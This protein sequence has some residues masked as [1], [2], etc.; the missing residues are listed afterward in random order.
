MVDMNYRDAS[1]KGSF[2]YKVLDI[3]T[4]N[5]INVDVS[6]LKSW[7]PAG[8]YTYNALANP[9][10]TSVF[11]FTGLNADWSKELSLSVSIDF[12]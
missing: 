10:G 2:F 12:S 4:R 11:F 5:D 9:L 8:K 1:N 6:Q 7:Y 3:Q